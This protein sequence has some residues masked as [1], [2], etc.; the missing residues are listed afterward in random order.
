MSVSPL[1]SPSAAFKELLRGGA[2]ITTQGRND[3]VALRSVDTQNHLQSSTYR[4]SDW[5]CEH[6]PN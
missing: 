4:C 1:T 5:L 2:V 3:G 6:T